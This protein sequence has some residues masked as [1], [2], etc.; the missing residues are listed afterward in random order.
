MTRT[1]YYTTAFKV[2]DIEFS[3]IRGN[4]GAAQHFGIDESNFRFW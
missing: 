2:Q 3:D 4:R 1:S